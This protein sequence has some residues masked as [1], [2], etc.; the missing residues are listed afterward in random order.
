VEIRAISLRDAL[1]QS[2]TTVTL[3]ASGALTRVFSG[4]VN[5]YHVSG[6]ASPA[7]LAL[8]TRIT[9]DDSQAA[10]LLRDPQFPLLQQA[11]V[12]YP[13]VG[14]RLSLPTRALRR[15][16]ALLQ[17]DPRLLP[18]PPN[19]TARHASASIV[20]QGNRLQ[21]DVTSDG[22]VYL[23]LKQAWYP[24]WRATVDGRRVPI[25]RADLALQAVAVPAGRHTVIVD[26]RP[27]S[28]L[29]GA[30]VSVA[31]LVFLLVVALLARRTIWRDGQESRPPQA[32]GD[33]LS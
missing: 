20:R 4:D 14:P 23:V 13:D 30:A 31:G 19:A 9:G 11:V 27:A 22:D 16:D 15:L 1:T 18:S 3:S 24:G 28:V 21:A 2:D 29:V 6:A 7:F 25:Y 17:G 33:V 5:I 12:S 26:Y 8:Q 10:A 32:A